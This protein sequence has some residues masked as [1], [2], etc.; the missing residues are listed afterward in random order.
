[1]DQTLTV[2]LEENPEPNLFTGRTIFQAPEVDGVV[3]V[4]APADCGLQTGEFTRV[5]VTDALPYDLV[6]EVV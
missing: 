6:G 4:H 3:Y 1:L 2:L 5:L